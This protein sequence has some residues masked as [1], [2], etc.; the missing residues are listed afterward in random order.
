[1]TTPAYAMLPAAQTEAATVIGGSLGAGVL[2]LCDHASNALPAA[3]GTLGLPQSGLVRHIAYDIGA[4]AVTRKLAQRLACP[5]VLSRHSRL[6]IDPN[7]GLDDPTLIM[8]LSDGA[9]I[10]GNRHLDGAERNARIARYYIPYHSAISAAIDAHLAAGT[11][12][13]I[14][15]IHS[16]TPLW[17]GAARHWHGA[18]LWDKDPRLAVPLLAALCAEPGLVIGD[19]EPYSGVLEGDTLWQHGS[20][21]G[22]AH[23]IV[24]I[25]QDLIAAPAGQDEWAARL[26][27]V[28]GQI[29]ASPARDGLSRITHFGSHTD[30]S[31][32]VAAR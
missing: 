29:L 31:P 6:L 2:L 19:N 21:R 11:V 18:V 5:A 25:R 9:V 32:E 3:Y 24:E 13:V 8:R 4:E 20:K 17:R 10:P 27:R 26:A 15:S 23:A 12:P 14:L 16:F 7:R 28:V 1:M 22:I 30:P